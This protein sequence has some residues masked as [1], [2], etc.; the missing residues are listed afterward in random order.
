MVIL[1]SRR[2]NFTS[3]APSGDSDP[4]WNNVV[5][6]SKFDETGLGLG[7]F[8]DVSLNPSHVTRVGTTT[9]VNTGSATI[10]A[11]KF[12]SGNIY[13]TTATSSA[14]TST[15]LN[16]FLLTNQEWTIEGWFMAFT[17]PGIQ[18]PVVTLSN[19][20]RISST[21]TPGLWNFQYSLNNFVTPLTIGSNLQLTTG[22]WYHLAF[23]RIR[24]INTFRYDIYLN[25][26]FTGTASNSGNHGPGSTSSGFLQ[27]SS[28]GG[29]NSFQFMVDDLRVTTGVARY[30]TGVN[31]TPPTQSYP[32]Q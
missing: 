12:G 10:P 26:I 17:A 18:R 6:L 3:Q 23:Q 22:I 8:R 25:G 29:N 30:P 24:N 13:F 11:P 4:Y 1:P 27:F 21:A 14:I 9:I 32:S 19:F 2:K 28:P 16:K 5:F 15:G 7:I 20:G 31:F